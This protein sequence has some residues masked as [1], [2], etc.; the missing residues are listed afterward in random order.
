MA[1]PVRADGLID[2]QYR[3]EALRGWSL[4]PSTWQELTSRLEPPHGK[5][6]VLD[7]RTRQDASLWVHVTRGEHLFAPRTIEA[8]QPLDIQQ[9]WARRRNT[10]WFQLTRDPMRHYADLR[11]ALIDYARQFAAD[12]EAGAVPA[13]EARTERVRLFGVDDTEGAGLTR[14]PGWPLC[15][16]RFHLSCPGSPV[17][18]RRFPGW[19]QPPRPGVTYLEKS[20][21]ANNDARPGQLKH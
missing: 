11:K 1:Q 10:T 20:Q 3:R 16:A 21:R 15:V 18:L 12:I 7:D 5:Q 14:A 19:C 6:P 2:Y 9:D 8:E 13:R 17:R 4:D